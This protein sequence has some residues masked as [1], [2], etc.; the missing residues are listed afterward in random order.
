VSEDLP[1]HPP[2][3]RIATLDGFRALAICSVLAFHYTVRWAPKHDPVSHLPAGAIFAGIAPFEYGWLG[4]ELFFVISGFVILMTLERCATIG[5]FALRRIARISPALFCAAIATSLVIFLLGPAD[6]HPTLFDFLCSIVPIDPKLF[7]AGS[8][9]VD[10]AYWTLWV[11]ARFY[12]LAALTYWLFGR[13]IVAPWL[14]LQIF[15]FAGRFVFPQ[16]TVFEVV[17][18][19]EYFP[20]FTLGICAYEIYSKKTAPIAVIAAAMIAATLILLQASF[21]MELYGGNTPWIIVSVNLAIFGLFVLFLTDHP[22]LGVFRL[23]AMVWLGEISY[24]LYLLHQNIGVS[25]MRRATAFGIPYLVILPVVVALMLVLARLSF[26]YIEKPAKRFLLDAAR[27]ESGTSRI[28]RIP[29]TTS[30]PNS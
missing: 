17:F 15:V 7:V 29:R 28:W 10:G 2:P 6:W 5:E 3:N 24:S 22:V 16:S 9:W 14:A 27:R 13:K 23:G 25:L 20:Y 12:I 1:S 26:L 18:F 30:G 21:G 11:E 8:Q 4:V 19:P